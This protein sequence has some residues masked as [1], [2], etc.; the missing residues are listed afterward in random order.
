MEFLTGSPGSS[1]PYHAFIASVTAIDPDGVIVKVTISSPGGRFTETLNPDATGQRFRGE[2][3]SFSANDQKAQRGVYTIKAEDN[4]GKV[5]T[6]EMPFLVNA[7]KP[8]LSNL[9]QIVQRT[10]TFHAASAPRFN[11][12]PGAASSISTDNVTYQVKVNRESRD[13]ELTT[14]WSSA[15]IPRVPNQASYDATYGGPP[16]AANTLYRAMISA[17][18]GNAKAITLYHFFHVTCPGPNGGRCGAPVIFPDLTATFDF[19]THP[20][21]NYRYFHVMARDYYDWNGQMVAGSPITVSVFSPQGSLAMSKQPL[22]RMRF[23]E[24][25]YGVDA[26]F[27]GAVPL[28]TY[29]YQVTDGQLQV[30]AV[31]ENRSFPAPLP[32]KPAE[33]YSVLYVYQDS[34]FPIEIEYDHCFDYPMPVLCNPSNPDTGWGTPPELRYSYLM[35]KVVQSGNYTEDIWELHHTADSA[36]H[37]PPPALGYPSQPPALEFNQEYRLI[38]CLSRHAARLTQCRVYPLYRYQ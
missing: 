27:Y 7:P 17:E 18:T 22:E 5:A 37:Y 4:E 13:Y 20:S 23:P 24:L 6:L 34:G 26:S 10:P 35:S 2:V 8:V 9:Q 19:G 30:S 29:T 12:A 16:L 21:Y 11:W 15:H 25:N 36:I 33:Y 3:Y 31:T 14:L 28:G 38:M 32:V 1:Y